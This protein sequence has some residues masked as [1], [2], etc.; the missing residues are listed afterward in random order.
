MHFT[1]DK[2]KWNAII[3]LLSIKVTFLKHAIKMKQSR[4]LMRLMIS[5]PVKRAAL[6]LTL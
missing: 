5:S 6:M 4:L 1:I 3:F 2:Y